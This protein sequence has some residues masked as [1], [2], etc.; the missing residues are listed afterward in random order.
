M[1]VLQNLL[2][3]SLSCCDFLSCSINHMTN[4]Q[5][6]HFYWCYGWAIGYKWSVSLWTCS[7][8]GNINKKSILEWSDDRWR[9]VVD[10]SSKLITALLGSARN[11]WPT[12]SAVAVSIVQMQATL[13]IRLSSFS[14]EPF[15]LPLC[16]LLCAVSLCLSVTLLRWVLCL[17]IYS[18]YDF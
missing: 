11:C 8:F 16:L 13:F 10:L 3:A 2:D 12:S 9:D 7:L 5:I 15:L 14:P 4:W 6:V 18:W 17:L 1:N